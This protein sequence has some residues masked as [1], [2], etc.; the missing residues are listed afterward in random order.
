MLKRF[1]INGAKVRE[2][3]S[4]DGDMLSLLPQP[5]YGLIFLYKWTPEDADQQEQSCPEDI[6]F[7]NQMDML[8]ADLLLKNQATKKGQSSA[9]DNGESG[10]HF[11]AFMPVD[12]KLWKL[13][14]L[15]RQP[16]CLAYSRA[17]PLTGEWVNQ[18]RPDIEARMFRYTEDHIDFAV[19]S[20][21]KDPLLALT[22]SLAS[23]VKTIN[24]LTTRLDETGQDWRQFSL[25]EVTSSR[26]GELE[27][28]LQAADEMYG[29]AQADI[30]AAPLEHA[31]VVRMANCTNAGDYLALRQHVIA[32]QARLRMDIVE[33]LELARSEDASASSRCG[34][35]GSKM[36]GFVR[37]M[38]AKECTG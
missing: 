5:I 13:D 17:G 8:N 2:V 22:S 12:D 33:E 36:Q 32:D 26:K 11:I 10:F 31:Y 23:N 25:E 29:L 35:L 20:L 18:V 3:V 24:L 27:N 16:M 21:V 9:D 6:W 38:K 28:F 4:L 19:L 34:D 30:D 37:M 7:A 15:E 1:G 14:G